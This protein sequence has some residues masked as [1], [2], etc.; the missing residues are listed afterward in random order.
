LVSRSRRLALASLFGALIFL[1]LG[2]LQAPTSDFL[3]VVEALLL[4]LSFLL[5]PKGGATYV[6]AVSGILISLVKPAFFPYDLVFGVLYGLMID[7]LGNI[8]RAKD[9]PKV[10]TARLVL[11]TTVST[12]IVGL[13]AYY[14]TAV[15]TNLVPNEFFLDLTVLLF[16]VG[17]GAVGGYVAVRVWNRNLKGRFE[18]TTQ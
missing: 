15:A 2:F 16:G 8:L 12:G 18:V 1:V 11:A 7:A 14:V 5:V 13:L 10:R 4:T 6:G 17:S 9:G 3:I